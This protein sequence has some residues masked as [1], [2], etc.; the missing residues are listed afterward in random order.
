VVALKGDEIEKFLARPDPARSIVLVFGPDAGLVRE[1]AEALIRA[2]VDDPRDPFQ[3]ARLEGDDLAGAPLRLL[4]EANTI[5]PF[6]GR[7]AVWVK[8]G[9]RNFAPAV[10]ALLATPSPDC[11]VVIEAG[12]LRRSAPLR[13]VCERARNAVTLPCY[14]DGERDLLRLIDDEMRENGLSISPEARAALVPLLGGDRLASRHE[15]RKLA[16]FA[17]GKARVELEDVIAVVSDASTLALDDLIDAAF[18]GRT[19]E[20]ELQFG[21][22]RTAATP[23]GT[24][25]S[26]A[27]RQIAQLHKARLAIEEGAS[28]SAAAEGIAP[29][30]PFSRKPAI[31]AALNTW[32]SARLA[33][34]MSQLAEAALETR[35]QS[36]MAGVIAQRA[37]LALAVNARRKN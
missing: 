31:E 12:E 10:E 3:L 14:A 4:D 32:T 30:V 28:V 2:S 15:L 9:A 1:R 5:P 16:L 36:A 35:R 8:A 19:S 20:L 33:R 26:T 23:P 34:A 25:V 29:F 17:R 18:A 7:R 27:L 21:K 37:L 11:R 13:V 24:I 6:G 22:A